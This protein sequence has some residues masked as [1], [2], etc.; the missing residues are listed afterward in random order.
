MKSAAQQIYDSYFR[1]IPLTDV[2][3]VCKTLL[4]EDRQRRQMERA[5]LAWQ[6]IRDDLADFDGDKRGHYAALESAE[7]KIEKIARRLR[8]NRG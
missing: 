7:D 4:R 5:I 2:R 3:E 6:E 8:K 1:G